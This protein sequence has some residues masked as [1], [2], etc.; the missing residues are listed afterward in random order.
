ME[1]RGLAE[2][3]RLEEDLHILQDILGRFG[4]LTDHYR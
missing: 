2:P 1:A 3:N 4:K